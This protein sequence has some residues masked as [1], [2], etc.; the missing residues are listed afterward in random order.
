M[1]AIAACSFRPGR[2]AGWDGRSTPELVAVSDDANSEE[3][4]SSPGIYDEGFP[5]GC[6][7]LDHFP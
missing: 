1:E 4:I 2:R 6:S 7:P 3:A 5:V